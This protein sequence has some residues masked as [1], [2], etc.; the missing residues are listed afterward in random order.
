MNGT[1]RNEVV[2]NA[3]GVKLWKRFFECFDIVAF[4]DDDKDGDMLL[5]PGAEDFGDFKIACGQIL[6]AIDG[7]EDEV[8]DREGEERLFSH[9]IL[10]IVI[11]RPATDPP[12][13]DE[14]V[15]EGIRPYDA[16]DLIA[17]RARD[18][19]YNGLPMADHSVEER[20]FSGIGSPDDGDS[21]QFTHGIGKF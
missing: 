2:A 3:Q 15:I 20:G 7:E 11:L 14:E 1:D 16:G 5:F 6:L 10:K 13:I 17:C 8:R 18:I 9:I 12:G 21:R 4:G 19:A